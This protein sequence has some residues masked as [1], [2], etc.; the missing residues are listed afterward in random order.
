MRCR[1]RGLV[2]SVWGML[3]RVE[4]PLKTGQ[5][6]TAHRYW[7]EQEIAQL[8]AFYVDAGCQKL[9]GLDQLASAFGRDKANVCRKARALGLTNGE[10]K[11][12]PDGAPS[13]R[14]TASAN[15][16]KA[17]QQNNARARIAANGHPRGMAGKKHSAESKLLMSVST[18]A[19]WDG[20]T[21]E[22]RDEISMSR[23]SGRFEKYGTL[24]AASGGRGSWKAG[25]RE[26][27]GQRCF[28]RSRWEANY[29]RYLEWLRTLGQIAKWEH[30]PHTFWFEG[31]KRGCVS[32][33]PDFRVTNPGDTVEWHEVKGWMDDRSKTKLARMAKYHPKEKLVVV[34]QKLYREIELKVSSL[35]DGWESGK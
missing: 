8:R 15:E 31:I 26:V 33:L 2:L 32:Y 6:Q 11:F 18:K 20:L 35:I 13:K 17:L 9:I 21:D 30:E 23:I 22:R 10:R 16:L 5:K 25:W 14:K 3:M 24:A 1:L 34:Q 7:T 29:A 19:E 27:G 28:F 12:F 4:I